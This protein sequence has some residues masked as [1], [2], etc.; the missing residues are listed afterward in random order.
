MVHSS[1]LLKIHEETADWKLLG[2][3]FWEMRREGKEK[4]RGSGLPVS[5][6]IFSSW[7]PWR[8]LSHPP[9]AVLLRKA[10]I[11]GQNPTLLLQMKLYVTGRE[12]EQLQIQVPALPLCQL[13]WGKLHKLPTFSFL[14]CKMGV[15]I[16]DGCQ[17]LNE[18][19]NVK[20]PSRVRQKL[21]VQ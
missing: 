2:A 21:D 13:I 8:G 14:V 4:G 9:P 11:W 20:M 5:I 7:Q 15:A 19:V 6:A 16:Q 3:F 17:G 10:Y 18:K 12:S 1:S